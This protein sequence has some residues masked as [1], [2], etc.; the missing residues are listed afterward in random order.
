MGLIRDIVDYPLSKVSIKPHFRYE[1][2]LY[3]DA[4][5]EAITWMNSMNNGQPVVPRSGY[6]VEFNALWYNVLRFTAA[7]EME[8]GNEERL[9]TN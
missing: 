4:K 2:L 5:G 7:M 6:I 9:Q 1:W 3:A 8:S